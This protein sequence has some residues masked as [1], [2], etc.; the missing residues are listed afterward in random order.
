MLAYFSLMGSSSAKK[1]SGRFPAVLD[2]AAS[3]FAAKGYHSTSMRDIAAMADLTPSA[4]YFHIPTKQSLLQTVYEEGV[5]RITEHVLD[6]LSSASDPWDRLEKAMTAHLEAILGDCAYSRVITRIFPS[7]VP[8]IAV[9]LHKMRDTYED[10][11]RN[12]MRDL[13]LPEAAN[14]GLMRLY[15]LGA[16]NWVPV[17]FDHRNKPEDIAKAMLQPFKE[18][19][20]GRT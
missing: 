4:I 3:L 6:S 9:E 15:F 16:M 14:V 1:Q 12:L 20:R 19:W 8:E 7:D 11:F 10:I 2:A 5:R 13:N 18:T 17:W